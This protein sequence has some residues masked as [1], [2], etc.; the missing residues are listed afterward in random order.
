MLLATTRGKF[1]EGSQ[2]TRKSVQAQK[3]HNQSERLTVLAQ[4]SIITNISIYSSPLIII[5][6][7]MSINILRE[8]S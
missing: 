6:S 1:L 2:I 5:S 3:L 4:Q 8:L 7:S